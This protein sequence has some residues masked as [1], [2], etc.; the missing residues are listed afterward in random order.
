VSEKKEGVLHVKITHLDALL[1]QAES[2]LNR[3][4]RR[5]YEAADEAMM[6]L[7]HLLSNMEPGDRAELAALEKAI[8]EEWVALSRSRSRSLKTR[9]INLRFNVYMEWLTE[10]QNT[11]WTC[12]YWNPKKYEEIKPIAGDRKSGEDAYTPLPSRMKS[13]VKKG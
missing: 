7:R 5:D 11:L 1:R 3:V 8:A 2:A 13:E 6:A 9:R 12:G 4:S 10:I